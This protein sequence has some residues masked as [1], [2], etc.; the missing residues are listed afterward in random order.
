[1]SLVF[2][3]HVTTFIRFREILINKGEEE[4]NRKLKSG[5]HKGEEQRIFDGT[6]RK[7]I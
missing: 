7:F 2:L 6:V 1:V 4:E 5:K 3:S